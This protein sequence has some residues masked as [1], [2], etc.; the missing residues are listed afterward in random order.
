MEYN[1]CPINALVSLMEEIERLRALPCQV[2]CAGYAFFVTIDA[3]N[4]S[5]VF[6]GRPGECGGTHFRLGECS[7]EDR[8]DTGDEQ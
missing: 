2:A 4:R 8:E 5:S 6:K 3:F 1:N 7:S